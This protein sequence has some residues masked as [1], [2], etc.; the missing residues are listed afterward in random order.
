MCV[1]M[2]VCVYVVVCK[3]EG[4]EIVY[5]RARETEIHRD[6]E[7]VLICLSRWYVRRN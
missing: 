5:V 4:G 1:Y 2:Y 6:R 3:E 7:S